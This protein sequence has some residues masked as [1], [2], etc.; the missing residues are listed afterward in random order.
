MIIHVGFCWHA[1]FCVCRMCKGHLRPPP[2][3]SLVCSDQLLGEENQL[4]IV[5]ISPDQVGSSD[6]GTLCHN[7]LHVEKYVCVA[8]R[9]QES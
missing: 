6:D 5:I 1:E 3:D 4:I 8:C 9:I 7:G 2:H